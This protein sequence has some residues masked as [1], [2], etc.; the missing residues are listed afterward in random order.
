M[1]RTI[2]LF[3]VL[4]LLATG[5]CHAQLTLVLRELPSETPLSTPIYVA[6]SFNDWQTGDPA[7]ALQRDEEGIYRLNLFPPIGQLEFK[8]TRGPWWTVEGDAEG[9]YR[10]NRSLFYDGLPQTVELRIDSWEDTEQYGQSTAAPN[11]HLI[12]NAFRIP[13]L[14]RLRRIWIYL[15]PDYDHSSERYPVLYMHDAQ[16]LFD[17][18]TSFSGEW[19]VDESLNQEDL[20]KLIV[21]GIDNGGEHRLDEYNPWT[22]PKYGGGEGDEFAAFVVETLKPYVDRHYRTR[23]GREDTGIMGSSM[24][25]LIAHYTAFAYP[26]VFGRVGIFS[27]SYWLADGVYQQVSEA[28]HAD[29]QTVYFIAGANESST[30]QAELQRMESLLRQAGYP[31]EDL[32]LRFHPDGAHAEWYWAREF[33]GAVFWLYNR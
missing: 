26:Q 28:G 19:Q 13:Q 12:S 10:P 2:F 31:A 1:K 29:G 7:Y 14:D 15:P 8:F 32:H 21:V 30:L 9:R 24:G 22:H 25:G 27:P 5:F 11:V 18:Q 17:R 3:S 33:P 4:H 23:P 20:P 6:G 16:N